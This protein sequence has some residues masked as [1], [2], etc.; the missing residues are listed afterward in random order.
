MTLTYIIGSRDLSDRQYLTAL[1]DTITPAE[2]AILQHLRPQAARTPLDAALAIID[3]RD[4]QAEL[5]AQASE[6]PP[7]HPLGAI[8]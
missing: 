8:R 6:L 1:V 2:W 3:L 4:A 5:R 7:G